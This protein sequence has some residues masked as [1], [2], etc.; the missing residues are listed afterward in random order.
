[1]KDTRMTADEFESLFV[2]VVYGLCIALVAWSLITLI[3]L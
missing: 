2:K 3:T 1:M